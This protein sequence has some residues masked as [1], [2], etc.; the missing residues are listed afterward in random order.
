MT[1]ED[2]KALPWGVPLLFGGGLSLAS[3]IERHGLATYLGGLAGGL[4]GLPFLVI[5]CAI[6]FGILMLTELTSNTATAATLL[7]V[8]GAL[9]LSLGQNPR[10]V[11]IPIALAANCSVHAAGR[12]AAQRGRELAA[13]AARRERPLRAADRA[14]RRDR[15]RLVAGDPR[16]HESRNGDGGDDTDDRHHDQQL[17]ER[18][19]LRAATGHGDLLLS[20]PGVAD[21]NRLMTAA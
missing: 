12:H 6:A 3:N 13:R 4:A 16:A 20:V 10:L 19:A 18:K 5:L 15:P 9:A 14:Q 2:T 21:A 8:G 7:P 17:D 11:M 1:W